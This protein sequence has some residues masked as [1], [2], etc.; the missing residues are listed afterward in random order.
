MNPAVYPSSTAYWRKPPPFAPA[1]RVF[2]PKEHGSWSLALEPIL[3]GL[4]IAPTEAGVALA[5]SAVAAFFI[6]RPMK[7]YLQTRD[8]ASEFALVVLALSALFGFFQAIILGGLAS[9]WPLLPALLLGPLYLYWDRQNEARAA[10]AEVT[11][12][13]LFALVPATM[14]ALAGY[15]V[16]FC[17]TLTAL[18]LARSIPAVLTVRTWLRRRKSQPTTV[19]P[20]FAVTIVSL[21]LVTLLTR[22]GYAP[23]SAHALILASCLRL[24]LLSS[25]APNWPAKR[26]GMIE[27]IFGL[28]YILI[29]SASYY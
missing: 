7:A 9:L 2:L 16:V 28:T 4:L 29:I 3:F 6:R 17:L 22:W 27:A 20:A 10:A 5:L 23:I 8:H 15:T 11:G 12:C 24:I 21:G 26:S 18:M 13:G 14:A 1:R 25:R 19:L